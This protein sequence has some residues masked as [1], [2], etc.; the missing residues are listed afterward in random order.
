MCSM[1]WTL[2]VNGLWCPTCGGRGRGRTRVVNT[3][4]DA[5][6]E[7]ELQTHFMGEPGSCVNYYRLGQAVPELKGVTVR[8][9]GT[10]DDFVGSCPHC[11]AFLLFGAEILRSV[12]V[13]VWPLEDAG[14]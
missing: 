13:A 7:W 1:Y 9:D 14:A 12:V 3:L 11:D 10:N 2:L 5:A 6:P 8:L 4:A